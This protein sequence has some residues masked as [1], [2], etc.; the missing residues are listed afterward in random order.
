VASLLPTVAMGKEDG[1]TIAVATVVARTTA[2]GIA[3]DCPN[4]IAGKVYAAVLKVGY[5]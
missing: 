2:F 1:C 4:T 5:T 3:G